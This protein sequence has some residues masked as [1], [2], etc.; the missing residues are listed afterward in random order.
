[1]HAIDVFPLAREQPF[2][3]VRDANRTLS[4]FSFFFSFCTRDQLLAL[5][6]LSFSSSGT[7]GVKGLLKELPG[8]GREGMRACCW[9]LEALGPAPAV[10]AFRCRDR[11]RWTANR[12]LVVPSRRS[13]STTEDGT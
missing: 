12:A 1:M 6:I 8:G 13:L 10:T 5:A 9:V 2:F 3:D 11:R 4:Y 7:M